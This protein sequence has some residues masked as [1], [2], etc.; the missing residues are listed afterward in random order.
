MPDRAFCTRAS[1]PEIQDVPMD[2]LAVV[3]GV[4]MFALLWILIEGVDRV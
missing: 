2:I 4:A 3:I 1:R